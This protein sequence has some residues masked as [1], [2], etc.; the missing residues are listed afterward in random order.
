MA[1]KPRSQQ[2][3]TEFSDTPRNYP[4]PKNGIR[5][6][7]ISLI[8]D[9]G[10][11]NREDFEDPKTKV[12]RPQ[13][14]C[15]QVAVFADLVADVVDYG[16]EVGKQQYRIPLNKSFQGN[17]E[18]INFTASPPKDADGKTIE[19]KPWG[20]HPTNMLTKVAKATNKVNVIES[21]DISEF[22][23][24]ALMIDVEVKET[25]GKKKDDD[26]NPVIYKNVNVKGLSK[27]GTQE[28]EEEDED[29]NPIEI[30][31]PVGA[32]KAEPMLITFDD[33]TA[34]QIKFIRKDLLKKIKLANDY[35]GSQMQ[36]AIEEFEAKKQEPQND[37]QEE[38]AEA[39]KPKA[40][41]EPKKPA[42][43]PAV[44]KK[45]KAPDFSYMDDDIPF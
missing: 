17:F 42:A 41:A 31:I 19:G 2:N 38:E 22:L 29:G 8:V 35:A 4:T 34:D 45:P 40:K 25:E 37:E 20:L 16:G 24:E 5:K 3:R 32:L 21:M 15:Q 23:G 26:G 13:K 28:T 44:V 33:A 6:A 39:P 36:K 1:F 12:I 18:G 7:R 30:P 27:V 9:L 10:E 14:P 11:Q 43:K